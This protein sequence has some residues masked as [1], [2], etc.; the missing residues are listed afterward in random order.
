MNSTKSQRPCKII[1]NKH[2]K[3][4]YNVFPG[5]R[6][7]IKWGQNLEVICY[8]YTSYIHIIAY[9]LYLLFKYLLLCYLFF[10]Y[11]GL[12]FPTTSLPPQPSLPPTLDPK[13]LW[14]CPCVL[15]TCSSQPFPLFPHYSFPP[16][17]WSLSVCS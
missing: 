11:S 1:Y 13:S 3:H 16:P 12:H 6:E 4:G 14:L 2:L 8:N 7:S 17:F 5:S 9:M 10:K 15:Y